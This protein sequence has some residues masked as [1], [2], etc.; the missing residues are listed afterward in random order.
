M[1]VIQDGL[2]TVLPQ[3][4]FA[5]FTEDEIERLICGVREVDVDLLRQCT[6]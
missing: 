5:F 6:E 2:A 4:L 1:Y 3:E